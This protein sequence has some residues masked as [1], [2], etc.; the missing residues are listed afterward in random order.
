MA[1]LAHM[2]FLATPRC[3][4]LHSIRGKHLI[5]TLELLRCTA[6][7]AFCAFLVLCL[8]S[9]PCRAV[10]KE[11]YAYKMLDKISHGMATENRTLVADQEVGISGPLQRF[12]PVPPKV[13]KAFTEVLEKAYDEADEVF[14]TNEGYSIPK[15]EQQVISSTGGSPTYGELSYEGVASLVEAMLP[16]ADGSSVFMDLGSGVGKVVIATALFSG[17]A[18][19]QYTGLEL[20]GIRYEEGEHVL[21]Q[22]RL[23]LGL[24]PE[25]ASALARVDLLNEDITTSPEIDKATHVFLCSSAFSAPGCRKVVQRILESPNFQML[26]TSRELPMQLPSHLTRIGSIP[27]Q[28]SWSPRGEGFIYVKNDL[29]QVPPALLRQFLCTNGVCVLP[30]LHPHVSF[31][32]QEPLKQCS[33]AR[34][35]MVFDVQSQCMKYTDHHY[36]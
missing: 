34:S 3:T 7:F 32:I 33:C 11:S 28:T 21:Q 23:L 5:K 16:S 29:N 13:Q 18:F 36:S 6:V 20:S 9:C 1:L 24:I 4:K 26:V 25:A 15:R 8:P 19:S 35:G 12:H 30:S 10:S 27:L 31:A 2:P 17:R 22:L 14:L